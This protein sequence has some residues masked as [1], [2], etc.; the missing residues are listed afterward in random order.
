VARLVEKVALVTGAGSGI[1]RAA[2]E[3]FIAEGA[4]VVAVE[5][6]EPSARELTATVGCQ[7]VIGDVG[8]PALWERAVDAAAGLG[9]LD[10]VFLNA[11]RYGPMGPIDELHLDAYRSTLAANVDGVVLG[12]RATVPALRARGGGS[13]V[14]TA[15]SAG[16]VASEVNPIYTLTKHAVIGF[17]RAVAPA[18]GAEGISL[19]AVCP[20]LVDTPLTTGAL[21]GADP[22][23][24]GLELLG[25]VAVVDV[26]VELVTSDGTGRC[27]VVRAGTDSFEWRFADWSDAPH[28]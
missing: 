26:V 17:V 28:A 25:T 8:D 10:V 14:V 18:L 9:G 1:G 27:L 24:L 21:G 16:L 5:H 19:D 23:S 22:A 7:V 4:A 2:V 15:S 11:G 6:H 20:G 12:V 13:I 3:R